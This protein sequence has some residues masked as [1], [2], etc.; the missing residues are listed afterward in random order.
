MHVC[1]FRY[2]TA[3]RETP[4][5]LIRHKMNRWRRAAGAGGVSES[6]PAPIVIVS[7]EGAEEVI[8]EYVI[9]S[10]RD[11][12]RAENVKAEESHSSS[13]SNI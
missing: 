2:P 3:A 9:A 11:V 5:H 4:Y 7:E 1:D 6:E 8:P 13:S 10:S 12:R